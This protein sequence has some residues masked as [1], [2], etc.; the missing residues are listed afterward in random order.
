MA[1]F[2]HVLLAKVLA[3][4]CYYQLRH[5]TIWPPET[6]A[7]F[8][9]RVAAAE[10]RFLAFDGLRDVATNELSDGGPTLL[11]ALESFLLQIELICD[12]QDSLQ[13]GQVSAKYQARCSEVITAAGLDNLVSLKKFPFNYGFAAKKMKRLARDL[14]QVSTGAVAYFQCACLARNLAHAI[15]AAAPRPRRVVHRELRFPIEHKLAGVAMLSYFSRVV[16]DLVPQAGAAVSIK[17]QGPHVSISIE[18]ADG[19]QELVNKTLQDYCLVLAG[20]QP[21]TLLFR[22]P[23]KVLEFKHKLELAE[24]EIRHTRDLLK[25]QERQSAKELG[26]R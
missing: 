1:Q 26:K 5:L 8:V 16:E 10:K 2:V 11:A 19:T 22:D 14:K 4:D 12:L 9:S 25:Y 6:H 20:E 18:T 13:I 7:A 24:L 21:P 23:L 3:V 15:A 17:Q